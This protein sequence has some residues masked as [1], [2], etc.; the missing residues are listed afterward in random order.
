MVSKPCSWSPVNFVS[1]LSS[2]LT[3][4]SGFQQ[5]VD[6]AVVF[7]GGD[8]D[9][10]GV[11]VFALIDEPAEAGA[12]VVEDGAAR[13]AAV[14]A[15]AAGGDHGDGLFGG[16]KVADFFAEGQSLEESLRKKR[17]APGRWDNS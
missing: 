8:G 14:S 6:A 17:V 11:R 15:V 4:T 9:G 10:Q 2:M 1:M 5:A 12:G 3:G 16:E 13:A 7:D